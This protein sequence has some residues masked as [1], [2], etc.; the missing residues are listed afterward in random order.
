MHKVFLYESPFRQLRTDRSK[1]NKSFS[2]GVKTTKT[3]HSRLDLR[4]L[5][6]RQKL[7]VLGPFL[8]FCPSN[9]K[10][11]VDLM[12]NIP[13]DY[14]QNL[15][16]QLKSALGSCSWSIKLYFLPFHF[17]QHHIS[18]LHCGNVPGGAQSNRQDIVFYLSSCYL[19]N[20]GKKIF[21]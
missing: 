18:I 9:V 2:T 19:L 7:R 12:N 16:S 21:F 20:D 17:T 8:A 3:W 5:T 13:P 6:G 4:C 10:K 15:I 1:Q 14:T 11:T